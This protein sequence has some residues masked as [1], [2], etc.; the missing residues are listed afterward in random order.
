[1]T[2]IFLAAFSSPSC[3]TPQCTTFP[4]QSNFPPLHPQQQQVWDV[5][6]QRLITLRVPPYFSAFPVK[7]VRYLLVQFFRKYL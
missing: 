5:G 1:M 3:L 2:N 4:D 6:S 7:N